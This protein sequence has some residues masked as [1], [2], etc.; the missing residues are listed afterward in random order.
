M[1]FSDCLDSTNRN[2]CRAIDSMSNCLPARAAASS[3]P[4]SRGRSGE[5][6][7]LGPEDRLQDIERLLRI[8]GRRFAFRPSEPAE[9]DDHAGTVVQRPRTGSVADGGSIPP[10]S[11]EALVLAER[12]LRWGRPGFDVAT[13]GKRTAREV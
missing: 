3:A 5:R 8:P 1:C 9:I 2:P 13:E 4:R 12:G 6:H 7:G 10:G 11:T